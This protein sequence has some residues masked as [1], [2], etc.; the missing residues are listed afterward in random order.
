MLKPKLHLLGYHAFYG[1]QNHLGQIN[2]NV[3]FHCRKCKKS[4]QPDRAAFGKIVLFEVKDHAWLTDADFKRRGSVFI[5][6]LTL[7]EL[8]QMLNES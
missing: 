1:G 7:D 6:R 5:G 4:W 8:R 2:P 3:G